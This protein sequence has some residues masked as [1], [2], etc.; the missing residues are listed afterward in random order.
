MQHHDNLKRL[1]GTWATE[2]SHPA[3]PGVAVRGTAT[4]EWL[5]G[6]KFVILRAT[7]DH[8]E[9]PNS[10]SLVG[11][12]DAGHVGDDRKVHADA[13]AP[14]ALHYYD[15]RGVFRAFKTRFDGDV[16]EG[17]YLTPAFKQRFRYRFADGGATIHG[18]WQMCE[19]GTWTDDLAI[20]YRRT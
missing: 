14:I 15:S 7:T 19:D 18:Q 10:I 13:E 9:F 12:T 8:P 11:V 2:A 16:W 4:V 17:E 5:D 3:M 6:E 20:T 1:L